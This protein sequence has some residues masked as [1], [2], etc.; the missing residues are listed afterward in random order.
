MADLSRLYAQLQNTGLQ[1]KDNALYQVIRDLIAN[2]IDAIKTSNSG[3]GGTGATGQQGP[4]GIQG[5]PGEILDIDSNIEDNIC[6]VDF[7]N[8]GGIYTSGS[9]IFAGP[10]GIF[11]QDNA[12]FFWDNVN[13]R[14]GIGT[15]TPSS[16]LYVQQSDALGI[17]YG[18]ISI[19]SGAAATNRGGYFYADGATINESLY[20]DSPAAAVGKWALYVAGL[21]DNYFNGNVGI[22]TTGPSGKLDVEQTSIVGTAYGVICNATGASVINRGGY[23]FAANALTNQ[24]IYVD[25]SAAAP[26]NYTIYSAG[27]AKNFFAGNIGIGI[28]MPTAVIHIQ[29][30]IAAASG[31]PLKFTAGVNLTSPEAGAVEWDGTNLFATQTTGP[32]R[33]TIAYTTDIP[34]FPSIAASTFEKAET[35]SDANVLTYTIGGTDQ[36]LIIQ[37]AVDVSALTG[38][39][40]AA[41]VTWKDSNNATQTSTVTLTGVTDGTINLPINAKAS[42]N[43]VISTVFVGVST[44]YNISA[45]I[46]R[47]K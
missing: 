4:Q 44:A 25:S 9:V 24:S 2:L 35:G 28:L 20:V 10:S 42:S 14:L 12:N 5:V 38:T 29:A 6:Y 16:K 13:K 36:F 33:K 34:P 39:S 17:V 22:G 27:L 3:S 7:R 15:T 46:T 45:F 11:A 31:A 21:A 1:Q 41:T 47:L 43:V 26:N 37:L 18:I 30:G 40:V 8:L 23:Y 19:A 32:T